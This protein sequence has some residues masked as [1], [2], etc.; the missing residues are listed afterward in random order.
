MVRLVLPIM[1]NFSMT[2][3]IEP[4]YQTTLLLQPPD[5]SASDSMSWTFV[6]VGIAMFVVQYAASGALE[7]PLM[8]QHLAGL[9]L[10]DLLLAG[11]ALLQWY[12]LDRTFQG[13]SP[14]ASA[15]SHVSCSNRMVCQISEPQQGIHTQSGAYPACLYFFAPRTL[16][17]CDK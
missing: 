16:R 10:L 4:Q 12:L 5:E 9:P 7:A 14:A 8:Q 15:W 13:M 11:T 17:L 6:T 2:D 1:Q 3:K